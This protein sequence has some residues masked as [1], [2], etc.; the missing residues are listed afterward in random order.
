MVDYFKYINSKEWK[1]KS[2]IFIKMVG[3]VCEKCSNNKTLGCHHITYKNLGNETQKDI[4][5]WCWRCHSNH[6]I[7][8]GDFL[9]DWEIN[10][11]NKAN[12]EH[13]AKIRKI[14]LAGVRYKSGK[15]QR[16]PS[17]SK[18]GYRTKREKQRDARHRKRE[19]IAKSKEKG[20]RDRGWEQ[21]K[22]VTKLASI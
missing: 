20:S 16:N 21:H 8:R 12:K 7:K 15:G 9:E 19:I 5:V 3:C 11:N 17:I 1:K 18:G 4:K 2:I 13:R 22:Y 14:E 6:H 10:K